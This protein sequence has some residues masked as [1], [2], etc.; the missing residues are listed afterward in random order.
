MSPIRSAVQHYVDLLTR[1]GR[2]RFSLLLT[3]AIML[4]AVLVQVGVTLFLRDKL[5]VEDF[6]H[7]VVFGFLVAPWA[8]YFVSTVVTQLETS[9]QQLHSNISELTALRERDQALNSQL[10]QVIDDMEH[11]VQEREIAQLRLAER[12]ALLRSFLDTSPDLVYY[13][14][15]ETLFSGCNRAMEA[16]TGRSESELIGL[17]PSEVYRADIAHKVIETDKQVFASN[18][19]LTY[20]QWLEYPDGSRAYFEVRKVPFFDRHGQRLGLLGFGRDITER[21]QYQDQLEQASRDKTTFIT[22]ISHELRTPLNGIVGL[23]HMLLDTP[24]SAAQS[25][26]MRTIH[27]SAVTLGHIFNDIIDLDKLDRRYLSIAPTPL[28]LPSFLEELETLCAMLA[29]QKGLQFVLERG[30]GLPAWVAAD[31]TRLRQVLWNLVGNAVKFTPSGQVALQV[32]AQ[33]G[34]AAGMAALSFAV[35]DSGIGI[36]P[37][38]QEKIFDLYY[39]VANAPQGQVFASGTGIGLAVARQLVEAMGGRIRVESALGQ[40]ACFYVEVALPL[41]A[42]PVVAAPAPSLA[43][44]IL[45][46]EDVELNITVA[47]ALLEKLGHTV[48]VARTGQEALVL[49]DPDDFDLLLLDIQLPD[50][51]G[52]EVVAQLQRRFAESLP[53]VVA[54]TANVTAEPQYYL[55]RGLAAVISK[56]LGVAAVQQ[57]IT[58]LFADL[59]HAD[60][61]A[62]VP[63]I[64]PPAV[65]AAILPAATATTAPAAPIDHEAWL[66]M[67]FLQDYAA[68]VGKAALSCSVDLFCAHLPDYL[69][70][71][72]AAVLAADHARVVDEAHKIKGAAAAI[73][74]KQLPLWAHALQS[75]DA[76]NWWLQVP[77]W[78]AQLKTQ[79]AAHVAVLRQ[80][81]AQ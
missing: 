2:V 40:G 66:D 6:L 43:L 47:V 78:L 45:L 24:L 41:V 48:T 67:T 34:S 35:R 49:A 44:D 65:P 32:Q 51:T 72:E 80:W 4:L 42:E 30:A 64:D 54:L 5:N 27:L 22:T 53:P 74:L 23:S 10:Q 81:L 20:E 19:P 50:I 3:C 63:Q 14:N 31:G 21:K 16:L 12:T 58:N 37:A 71:L 8:I 17:S 56:P 62:N 76:A 25:Q 70:A 36:A 7:S 79:H 57:V 28:A 11:E 26:Q 18:A 15:Q 55:K 29:E 60:A 52:F 1:L 68:V 33:A 39:Q 75:A 73:G 59:L 61:D 69:A 9:R 77:G 13:R 38:Q 46:V